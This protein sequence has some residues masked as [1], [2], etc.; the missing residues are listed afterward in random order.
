[1]RDDLWEARLQQAAKIARIDLRSL[2]PKKSDAAK[3]LL[4]AL[5][6]A[7]TEA[8]NGLRLRMLGWLAPPSKMG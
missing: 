1:M 8:S 2:G 3:V 5:P 7:T 4:E 6:K